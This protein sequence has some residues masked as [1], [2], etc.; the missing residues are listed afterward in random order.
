L[1]IKIRKVTI[2]E[3]DDEYLIEELKSYKSINKSISG[4]LKYS[5]EIDSSQANKVKREIE[6]K[7]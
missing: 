7:E 1:N 3:T 5:F 6:K 4:D 2:V